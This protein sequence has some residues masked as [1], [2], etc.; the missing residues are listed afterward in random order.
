[1]G[2][3]GVGKTHLALGLGYLATLAG[4][5][6]RFMTATDLL[7]QLETAQRQGRLKSFLQRSVQGLS[8]L[9]INVLGYLPRS[10]EQANLFP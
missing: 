3:S 4:F 9:I 6:T 1:M 8:L 10:R 2:P 7:L 5:K